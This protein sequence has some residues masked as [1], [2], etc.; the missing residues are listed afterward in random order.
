MYYV[1]YTLLTKNIIAYRVKYPN[2]V[3]TLPFT[4]QKRYKVI[5]W[6]INIK[7]LEYMID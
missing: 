7:K 1:L 2:L 5:Y 3:L 4:A 6:T